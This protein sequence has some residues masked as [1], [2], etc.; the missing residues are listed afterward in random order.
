M[1]CWWFGRDQ[2][3]TVAMDGKIALPVIIVLA[4]LL[5]LAL[6]YNFLRWLPKC[7]LQYLVIRNTGVTWVAAIPISLY[8]LA[9]GI[10][11]V[12]FR[13]RLERWACVLTAI[14]SMPL[15]LGRR[16]NIIIHYFGLSAHNTAHC[17]LGL[18]AIIE[19]LLYSGLAINKT[20]L[21]TSPWDYLVSM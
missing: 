21:R 9:N 12:L 17:I 6:S 13:D 11:L 4:V 3:I 14:N 15:F 7:R 5:V 8:I 16:R 19:G 20:R 2:T 10:V 18:V 1:K